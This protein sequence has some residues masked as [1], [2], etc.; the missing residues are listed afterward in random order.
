M[1]DSET[2]LA[3]GDLV[4]RFQY[5]LDRGGM[6]AELLHPEAVISSPAGEVRGRD[7]ILAR[8]AP[9]AGSTTRHCWANMRLSMAADGVVV[10]RYIATA[11]H[12]DATRK[13]AR[14]TLGDAEDHF[15]RD[16]DRW[17]LKHSRFERIFQAEY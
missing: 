6:P 17:L 12:A 2:R 7:A 15:V 1:V 11:W 9:A 13:L 4:T 10:A 16:G 14:M 5:C 3:I 8:P